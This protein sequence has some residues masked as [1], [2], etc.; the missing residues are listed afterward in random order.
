METLFL[1]IKIKL[2]KDFYYAFHHSPADTIKATMKLCTGNNKNCIR[3]LFHHSGYLKGEL[4]KEIILH[5][6]EEKWIYIRVNKCLHI[7]LL[8]HDL[9]PSVGEVFL[10]HFA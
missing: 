2:K 9:C 4:I 10:Q 8:I 3:N 7:N 5:S 1:I 6:Q